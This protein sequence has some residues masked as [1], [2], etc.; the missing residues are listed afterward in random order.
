MSTKE[1]KEHAQGNQDLVV[2]NDGYNIIPYLQ[3]GTFPLRVRGLKGDPLQWIYTYV[4]VMYLF[5]S[6]SINSGLPVE[7][8]MFPFNLIYFISDHI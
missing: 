1:S 8:Y 2:I 3:Q 6:L 7:V 5:Y 4:E